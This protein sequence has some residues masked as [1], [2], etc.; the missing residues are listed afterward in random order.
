MFMSSAVEQVIA[1][2]AVDS[3]LWCED[4]HF[5]A[6][7]LLYDIAIFTYCTQN[8]QWHV[9][10]ESAMSAYI[11]LLNVPGHFDVLLG[12]DGAP[13]VPAAAHTYSVNRC[14]HGVSGDVWLHLQKI[15]LSI[16]CSILRVISV[17]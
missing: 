13:V 3:D 9:F 11:C 10:N 12:T 4:G 17:V 5:A 2:L 8:K 1:G 6:I 15:T 16:M 7:S 14:N